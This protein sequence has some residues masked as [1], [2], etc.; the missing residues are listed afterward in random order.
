MAS[1]LEFYGADTVV[2]LGA[3]LLDSPDDEA[4]LSRSRAFV[5]AVHAFPYKR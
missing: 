5:A 4:L 3:S 1:V 2:L